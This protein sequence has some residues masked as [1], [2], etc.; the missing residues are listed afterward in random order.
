[1]GG[2]QTLTRWRDDV[3]DWI[4]CN[5]QQIEQI[6][7]KLGVPQ[8]AIAGAMA[9]ENNHYRSNYASNRWLDVYAGDL[10]WGINSGDTI[11]NS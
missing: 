9:K 10:A 6:A 8:E 7:G 3:I 5:R 4:C 1:M 2:E 11:H